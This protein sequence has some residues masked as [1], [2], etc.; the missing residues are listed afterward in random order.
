MATVTER[1][2]DDGTVAY[3]VSYRFGGRGSKQGGLTFDDRKHADSFAAACDAH[4]AARALEM[5]GINPDPRKRKSAELTVADWVRRHIDGQTGIEQTTIDKYDDY[6]K[7]D[8]APNLGD[9]PLKEL[10]S[11]DIGRWVKVMETSGGRAGTGHAPKTLKN[12]Y[13]FLSGALNA[14]VAHKPPLIEANPCAGRRL[15][16]GSAEASN[17]DMRMLSRDEFADLL[18]GVT[19]HWKPVVKFM[20]ASGV[21][22]GEVSALQPR[23]VNVKNGTIKIRQAWKYSRTKGYYLGPPKTKRSR[24]YVDVPARIL[25]TL[26]LSNEWVFTNTTG[27]PIR[28]HGFKRRVWDAAIR[29]AGLDPAPTPHDLRHTYASWQL[30]GGTPI[31]IVSRQLGHESIQVTVDIYGDVDRASSKAAADFMDTMLD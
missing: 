8:I 31:T 6:L 1:D 30:T 27:G 3:L 19:E 4:G 23:H 11:Q 7:N 15:S 28:Y 2:R 17:E 18:E 14:A 13:G 21:R 29:R 10:S 22:W 25:E 24:R 12:K 26:D 5:H 9:I 20:V 16:R